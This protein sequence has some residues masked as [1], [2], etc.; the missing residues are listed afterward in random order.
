MFDNTQ[1]WQDCRINETV[2][3]FF[4]LECIMI[5]PSKFMN[6][7]YIVLSQY[8]RILLINKNKQYMYISRN[9]NEF[10]KILCYV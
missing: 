8:H 9:I 10:Q 6:S 4:L 5:K 7:K 2:R 1:C 3:D